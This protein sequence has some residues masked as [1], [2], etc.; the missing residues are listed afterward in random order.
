VIEH[1]PDPAATVERLAQAVAPGGLLYLIIDAHEVSPAF[2]MHQ[3]VQ[4]LLAAAPTLR[5]LQ[6]VKHDGDLVDAFHASL[7]TS[8]GSPHSGPR[9]TRRLPLQRQGRALRAGEQ[10]HRRIA[11]E[12]LGV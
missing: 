1:V 3:H 5:A 12:P 2:P 6:H 10:A 4:D 8:R 11:M 7:G 9:S